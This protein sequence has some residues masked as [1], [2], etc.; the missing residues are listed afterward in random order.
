[1]SGCSTDSIFLEVRVRD[2]AQAERLLSLFTSSECAAAIAGDLTEERQYRG[3]LWFWLHVIRTTLAFWRSALT[4]A[5]IAVLT[6][7]VVGCVFLAGP[8][9]G[10]VAAINLF[11][12]WRDSPATWIA[13]FVFWSGGAFWTGASLVGMAPVRGMAACTTLAV[14]GVSAL[15]ATVVRMPTDA[16]ISTTVL[17]LSINGLVA[18]VM[19]VIGGSIARRRMIARGMEAT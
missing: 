8:A 10:G 15:I 13:L 4:A 17:L 5:A 1:M 6:L 2:T 9:F 18:C 19:V 3:G 12:G 11:P 16:L 7:V 14:V